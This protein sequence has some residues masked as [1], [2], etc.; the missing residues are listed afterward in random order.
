MRAAPPPNAATSL[1]P[2][3]PWDRRAPARP[4]TP[5]P[6]TKPIRPKPGWHSRGYLPHFDRPDLHQVITYRLADSLPPNA[7]ANLKAKLTEVDDEEA[8]QELRRRIEHLIDA[9]HG[10]CLLRLPECARIVEDAFFHGDGERYRLLAWVVMPNH[11]HVCIEPMPGW[12]VSR[13]VQ[14]WKSFSGR[15]INA[16]KRQIGGGSPLRFDSSDGST[17]PAE[18]ELG[19]PRGVL[20]A[21]ASP[22]SSEAVWIREYWDRY[23]RDEPHYANSVRYIEDNPVK[24]RLVLE[25]AD[26]PFSSAAWRAGR[27]DG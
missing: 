17:S 6:P 2:A 12:A 21:G 22:H 19:G 16:V 15:R 1:R 20:D 24:A 9:G 8:R 3:P 25:P 26:W 13:I 18:L 14:S 10:S 23:I 7:I 5:I 27:R 11:V 4:A